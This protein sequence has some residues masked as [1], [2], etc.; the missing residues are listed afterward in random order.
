MVDDQEDRVVFR[1]REW[2][3]QRLKRLA[4]GIEPEQSLTPDQQEVMDALRLYAPITIRDLKCRSRKV[5][6]MA[7]IDLGKIDRQFEEAVYIL[8]GQEPQERMRLY[9][10]AHSR[11]L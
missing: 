5:R 1:S 8:P 7:T 3:M 11:L 6:R 4:D 9:S 10:V 2:W